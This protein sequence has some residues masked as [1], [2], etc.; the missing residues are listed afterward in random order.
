MPQ[1]IQGLKT[2]MKLIFQR[3]GISLDG[4]LVPNPHRQYEV[5]TPRS[6]FSPWNLDA[7][8]VDVFN[9]AK[10]FT[11]VD[12]YRCYE[13]WSLV[14]ESAKLPKGELLEVGAWRGGTGAVI[15]KSA[16]QSEIQDL[17]HV[18]D[19]FAG[20]VKAGPKDS[21]Y[22]GGEH[23]DTS[24]AQVEQLYATLGLSNIRVIQGIFPEESGAQLTNSV[25][26]FCHIDVDV[27]QSA[28][29]ILEWV[30]P[31]LVRGGI[32]VYDDY[33]FDSCAGITIHV[34]EQRRYKDR[35]VLHNLNGHAILVKTD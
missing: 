29:D 14:A 1:M 30:W 12:M 23:S 27:Y 20:V 32:V 15:G 25:F 5:I 22:S 16:Q 19:T 28:H 11:L 18:C 3:F 34:D 4:E 31:R 9:K 24:K 35:L 10:P 13:L 8:F 33:G 2:V 7:A 6:R 21:M 17:V 26:R